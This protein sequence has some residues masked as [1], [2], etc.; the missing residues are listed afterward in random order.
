MEITIDQAKA[1][2]AVARRGTLQK[3][4]QELR[5]GHSAVMYLLKGLESQLNLQL[6]DR[7]GYRNQLSPEGEIVLKHCRRR[8]GV[9]SIEPN[10]GHNSPLHRSPLKLPHR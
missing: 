8:D 7:K 5:K 2:D 10:C 9:N 1:L 6:F 4:A 3:A